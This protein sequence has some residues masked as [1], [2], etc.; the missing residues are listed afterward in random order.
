MLHQSAGG[1]S[2]GM[3]IAFNCPEDHTGSIKLALQNAAVEGSSTFP[4]CRGIWQETV[5]PKEKSDN[6]QR[7]GRVSTVF[8]APKGCTEMRGEL[9]P[10]PMSFF[11]RMLRALQWE[12]EA[13]S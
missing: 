4:T 7:D 2:S 5:F 6:A 13:N 12:Q 3:C 1:H 8:R 11:P 9:C 10:P